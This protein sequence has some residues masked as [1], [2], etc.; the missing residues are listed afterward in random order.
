MDDDDDEQIG[1]SEEEEGGEQDDCDEDDG[2]QQDDCDEDKD[3]EQDQCPWSEGE[4][5]EQDGGSKNAG[6]PRSRGRPK[7]R[8]M[9]WLCTFSSSPMAVEMLEF[10][11]QGIHT[12]D[13]MFLA[14]QVRHTIL[15]RYPYAMGVRKRDIARHIRTHM[16]DGNVKMACNIHSL[17]SLAE[18]LRHSLHQV[19]PNTE[20]VL[21][22][23]KVSELYLKVLAQMA[24]IYRTVDAKKMLF[25]R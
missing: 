11:S 25:T 3:G 20:E 4:G 6:A 14:S 10:I 19:D 22:D 23:V 2:S 18:T 5:N 13:I 17:S 9:C 15:E 24:S 12:M 7:E 1:G 21:I 8:N 16:L